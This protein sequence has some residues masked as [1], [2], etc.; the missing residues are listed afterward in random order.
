MEGNPNFLVWYNTTCKCLRD[1]F[2]VWIAN[3]S[4]KV[5]KRCSLYSYEPSGPSGWSLSCFLMRLTAMKR[6]PVS[7]RKT[8]IPN[9]GRWILVSPARPKRRKT[10][11]CQLKQELWDL[12]E[13]VCRLSISWYYLLTCQPRVCQCW[14]P[15]LVDTWSVCRSTLSWHLEHYVYCV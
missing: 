5:N 7:E 14:S 11:S 8:L 1:S 10:L 3:W 13:S 15:L 4:S 9:L 2:T 12:K 6:Q